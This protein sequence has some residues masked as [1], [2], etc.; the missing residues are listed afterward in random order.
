M[1]DEDNESPVPK[2]RFTVETEEA[3][4][5]ENGSNTEPNQAPPLVINGQYIKDFSFEA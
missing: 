2:E 3:P 5:P 4:S 1:V